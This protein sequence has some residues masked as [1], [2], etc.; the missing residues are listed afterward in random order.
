[1]PQTLPQTLHYCVD[2]F[3]PSGHRLRVRLQINKPHPGGQV[4]SL[5]AW[6]PGS[7]L[8]RDFSRHIETLEAHANGERIGVRKIDSHTWQFARCKGPLAIDIVVYAWDLSVRG[9]HVDETH[10]FFN[11]TSVFLQAK[12]WEGH[13]CTVQL[14]HPP[15]TRGWQAYTSM[16]QL[17]NRSAKDSLGFFHAPDYDALIDHPFEL[18]KPQ[19]VSFKAHGLIH[20]M[21]FTGAAPALDLKRIAR[22]T[23]R[24]CEAQIALFEPADKVS[25]VRDSS[26]KYVF[27]T[28]VTSDGYGGL[29]HRASTALI[30][31]RK[32][33]PLKTQ[34]KAPEGYATFL[35]LVSH[36]YFHTW[37]VKRIKPAA[38]VPYHLQAPDHTELLWI[39]EGFTSY[40][41][42]LMALRSGVID[43]ATYLKQ[44]A[45]TVSAVHGG[46]GRFK[47]SLGQS[48][49][50]AW[51]KYYKQDENAPNAIVSYY[52]KGALV[53]LGLD[54]TIRAQSQG[55][56]SLDDVMRTLWRNYG[57]RF[58]T[59]Q[60][61]GLREHE[62]PEIIR[63]STGVN[64]SR[65]IRQWAYACDDVPLAELL[66]M[67]GFKLTW[68]T[69]DELPGMDAT[70]KSVSGA[71]TVAQVF[72]GGAAHLGGLSAKDTLVAIN[73]LRIGPTVDSLKQHLRALKP[74]DVAKVSAFRDDVLMHLSITLSAPKQSV[75]VIEPATQTKD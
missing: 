68:K 36:E 75:C 42:D 5:P 23:Q 48:S 54:L 14:K 7:Y 39:F 55:R 47:Q 74:K 45:K 3:D 69:A 1:M 21:V 37:H 30:A 61:K 6:I 25:P 22:D 20:E 57:K 2:P 16:P 19:V 73:G 11:G 27:M 29:E 26:G 58:Y 62:L 9:A 31:S 50:D 18:G 49:F 65:Q 71:L 67:H 56:Y 28:L 4:V 70:F 12:G 46:A 32:D 40:Y 66:P 64:V 44:L 60:S 59:G 10:A 24:I 13:A 38:F 35:G 17:P 51:T 8:I 53:A 43:Q 63:Q 72:E 52:A 34:A 33:L 41:D 15:H